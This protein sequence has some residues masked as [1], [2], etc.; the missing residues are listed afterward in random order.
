MNRRLYAVLDFAV[1]T[2]WIDLSRSGGYFDLKIFAAMAMFALGLR[3]VIYVE[4]RG[5]K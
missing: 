4:L 1:A 3:Q 2:Y 5:D